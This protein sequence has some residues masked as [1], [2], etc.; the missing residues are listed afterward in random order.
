VNRNYSDKE[1][2][3]FDRQWMKQF[4]LAWKLF[5]SLRRTKHVR[6]AV[7]E[8]VDSASEMLHASDDEHDDCGLIIFFLALQHGLPPD[9]A[10]MIADSFMEELIDL[11][12]EA[13]ENEE[14]FE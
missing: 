6:D 13:D 3:Y 11:I 8:M 9:Y 2:G 14:L 5:C 7:W 1:D 10:Q 4:Q 12:L